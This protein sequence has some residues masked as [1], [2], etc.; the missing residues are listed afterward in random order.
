MFVFWKLNLHEKRYES[1]GNG[2]FAP[3]F[4][5]AVSWKDGFDFGFQGVEVFNDVFGEDFVCYQNV[6]HLTS[7]LWTC[8]AAFG[9][10]VES[11]EFAAFAVT[12]DLDFAAVWALEFCGVAAWW[13]GFAAACTCD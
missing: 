8:E 1:E 5:F 4:D 11:A 7:P 9:A 10:L 6:T 12:F 3:S 13:N 2:F